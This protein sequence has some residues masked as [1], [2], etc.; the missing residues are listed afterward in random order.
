MARPVQGHKL[1]H[2]W[3]K[4]NPSVSQAELA[5]RIDVSQQ[6]MNDYY[7]SRKR[8]SEFKRL[9]LQTECGIDPVTWLT[10]D[11]VAYL[12]KKRQAA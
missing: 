11:E 1:L 5:R 7:H 12:K 10:K 6:T 8:P 2:Q 3:F 9:A 4:S